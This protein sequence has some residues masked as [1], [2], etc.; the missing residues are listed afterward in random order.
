MVE[1]E[2][3]YMIKTSISDPELKLRWYQGVPRYAWVVLAVAAFGWLFDA[4]DQNLFTLVRQPSIKELIAP[5]VAAA[6]LDAAAKKIGGDITS[7]FLIGWAVGGFFFGVIGDKL[8]RTRTMIVTICIYALFTG[9]N[10]LVQ[11]PFQYGVGRFLTALGVG[12]EFAAGASLVAEVWPSRS[13]PLALGFLQ[14][15]SALGNMT[16]AVIN[17]TIGAM[18]WRYVFYMGALPALTVVWIMKS[19]HEP[20]K[21]QE[22]KAKAAMDPT[23]KELGRMWEMFTDPVLRRNTIA[24]VLL[25]AAGVGGMW[26]V[27]FFL[28]DLTGSVLAP[29]VKHLPKAEAAAQLTRWRSEVFFIQNIGAAIGMFSFAV[30]S[31]RTGRKPAMFYMF[32]LAF[33]SEQGTFHYVDSLLSAQIWSFFLGVCALAPFSAYCVYFPELYPTRLRATGVGFCYN[34]A[35]LVAAAAPLALGGLARHFASATDETAGLRTAARIV[36]FIYVAGLIGL[37]FAPETRGKPL[38][39]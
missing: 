6:Q 25:A 8:G 18:D 28:P 26:G 12:G 16:A 22:A 2:R 19:V 21:W 15:L 29:L 27:G 38:P 31:E 23:Q 9:L 39:E 3:K 13:R 20:E 5:Y 7:V 4:M 11:N 37:I 14:A 24:G 35:R 1:E 17:Y 30:I 33:C 32:I 10:G 36:A 34:C